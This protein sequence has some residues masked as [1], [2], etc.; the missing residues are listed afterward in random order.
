MVATAKW[1]DPGP[2]GESGGGE[3]I[4]NPNGFFE[5]LVS[6]KVVREGHRVKEFVR[7]GAAGETNR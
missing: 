4:L 2:S 5:I 7:S 1:V 3:D 6:K